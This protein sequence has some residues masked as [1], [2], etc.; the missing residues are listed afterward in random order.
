[1]TA[2]FTR[3]PPVR[4][5]YCDGQVIVTPADQDIFFISAEKAIEAC[6]NAIGHEERIKRYTDEV[7]LPLKQFCEFNSEKILSCYLATPESSVLPVYVVGVCEQYD[8]EL[9]SI[10]SALVG[11]FEENG[12]AV[13]VS[14]LPKCNQEELVG[15]F[16]LEN[17]LVIYG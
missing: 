2:T 5:T 13:Q 8:F 4:L 17:A 3:K 7:I 11:R 1:M 6:K 14:Q 9:A 15:F 12:W 10:L 16:N